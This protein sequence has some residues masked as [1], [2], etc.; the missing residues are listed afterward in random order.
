MTDVSSPPEYA[1]T[2]FLMLAF[3]GMVSVCLRRGRK[4][5]P[6][7]R[8]DHGGYGENE[9]KY[10]KLL[11][12]RIACPRHTDPHVDQCRNEP[13]WNEDLRRH[14]DRLRAVD[15]TRDE[16]EETEQQ[17]STNDDDRSAHRLI[18]FQ[19]EPLDDRRPLFRFAFD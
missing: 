10:R 11:G 16:N 18:D 8:G 2:T 6:C 13:H 5:P 3:A 15:E 17:H 12:D 4:L 14:H 9:Q 7:E 1:R 19:T